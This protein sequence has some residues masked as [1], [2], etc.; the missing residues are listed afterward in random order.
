[1]CPKY[2]KPGGSGGFSL[3][4]LAQEAKIERDAGPGPGVILVPHNEVTNQSYLP[5]A[6]LAVENATGV[7][8]LPVGVM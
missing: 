2:E 8:K 6:K 3:S 1:M 4:V 7:S 5:R